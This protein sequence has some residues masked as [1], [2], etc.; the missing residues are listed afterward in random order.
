MAGAL[1]VFAGPEVEVEANCDQVG[2]VVG[3]GV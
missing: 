2:N 1:R 3:S